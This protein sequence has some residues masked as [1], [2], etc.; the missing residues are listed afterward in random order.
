MIVVIILELAFICW[1]LNR[2]NTNLVKSASTR[3]EW[4]DTLNCNITDVE[5]AV[6]RRD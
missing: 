2:I 6:N 4:L 5:T 1:I 3:D